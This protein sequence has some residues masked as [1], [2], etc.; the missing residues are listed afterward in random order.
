MIITLD[1]LNYWKNFHDKKHQTVLN[2]PSRDRSFI[3]NKYDTMYD[4]NNFN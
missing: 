2:D 3:L 1:E 4:T